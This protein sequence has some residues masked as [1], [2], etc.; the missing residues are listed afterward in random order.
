LKEAKAVEDK[1]MREISMDEMDRVSGGSGENPRDNT[2]TC[3]FCSN[4][5]IKRILRWS[6]GR[7]KYKCN[8]CRL[9]WTEKK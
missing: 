1:N 6:D 8:K 2:G 5:N 3:P 9:E 7:V 4:K